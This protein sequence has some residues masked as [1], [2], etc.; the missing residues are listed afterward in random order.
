MNNIKLNKSIAKY[1]IWPKFPNYNSIITTILIFV[2]CLIISGAF[3]YYFFDLNKTKVIISLI[4]AFVLTIIFSYFNI[5]N[6]LVNSSQNNNIS[7]E[8]KKFNFIDFI[9]II[10]YLLCLTANFY[11]LYASQTAE[12]IISPWQ[13]VSIWFFFIYALTSLILL[14]LIIRNTS[15]CNIS[16]NTST[17]ENFLIF[18]ISAFYFL[19]FSI[20]WLVYKINYGFDPLIHQTTME[21][22]DKTGSVD[23]KPLYYLGQYSLLVIIH[24]LTNISIIWLDKLL[25][26]LFAAIFLPIILHKVLIKWFSQNHISKLLILFLLIF[27]YTFFIITTPQ[28]LSYLFLLLIILLGII[29][30]NMADLILIYLLAL[31]ALTIQPIA[32]LPALLFAIFLTIFYSDNSKI[33]KYY[34]ALIFILSSIILPISFYFLEKN[35]ASNS[36]NELTPF[37]FTLPKFI[38]PYQDNFIFNFIY[39]YGFNIKL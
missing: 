16:Y 14:L 22:I 25:V 30:T 38:I 13:V 1:H 37:I 24:K 6:S 20:A 10:I 29:C 9:L 17:S 28:N 3:V 27:P 2:S 19:S 36:E 35:I 26:P 11:L 12:S 4:L 31:A 39:L 21:L 32:G 5:K 7:K 34:F 8:K 15:K 18:L 23:P 33:K